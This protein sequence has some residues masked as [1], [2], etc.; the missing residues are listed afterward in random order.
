MMT[1]KKYRTIIGLIT[2]VLAILLFP[3]IIGIIN[4][5]EL[6]NTI[7]ARWY[8]GEYLGTEGVLLQ[9]KGPNCGP[10]A[11]LMVFHNFGIE[12]SIRE[13]EKVSGMTDAGTSMFGLKQMAEVKGLR[14]E[15]W[16]YTLDDFLTAPKP[17]ILFVRGDH[18]VVVDS[19][20]INNQVYIRDPARGQYNISL[21]GLNRI[22]KGET[23]IFLEVTE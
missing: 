8:G 10:A 21:N 11:L 12:S 23:L 14:A 15:G 17:A 9:D 6:R 5:H 4:N 22:W 18:F 3:I 13:I 20:S 1:H 7:S 16:R 19:I 2:F